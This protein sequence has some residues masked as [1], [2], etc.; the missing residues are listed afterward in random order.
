MPYA[1]SYHTSCLLDTA[2]V[3]CLCMQLLTREI[4]PEQTVEMLANVTSMEEIQA[5]VVSLAV[6]IIE[7]LT[8]DAIKNE[9]V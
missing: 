9:K 2:I 6:D 1:F 8:A 3:L 7:N 5:D 4:P